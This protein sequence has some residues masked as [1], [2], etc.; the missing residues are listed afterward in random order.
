MIYFSNV[1]AEER[2]LEPKQVVEDIKK[3]KKLITETI[4]VGEEGVS[5]I[6]DE[7]KTYGLKRTLQANSSIFAPLFIFIIFFLLYLRTRI[8]NN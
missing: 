6:V 2:E 1:S 5:I 7:I 3:Q 4:N 8:K